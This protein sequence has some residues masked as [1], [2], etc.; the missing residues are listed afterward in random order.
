[1]LVLSACSTALGDREAELGFGGLAVQAGVKSAVASL[2]NVN[3]VAT[4]ALITRFY[5]ELRTAPIKAEALRQA[6]IALA[7]GTVYVDNNQILGVEPT[8][9]SLPTNTPDV[10]DRQ[11]THPY[12]WASFTM[13]GNPW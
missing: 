11:F 1:L 12:Y 10:R 6:Q 5:R 9:I 8:G 3:D 4:A 13:I 2:W 7:K